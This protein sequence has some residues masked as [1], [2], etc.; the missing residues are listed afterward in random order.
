MRSTRL[1]CHGGRLGAPAAAGLPAAGASL[2]CHLPPTA[3]RP[4]VAP[5]PWALLSTMGHMSVAAALQNS[6]GTLE[7]TCPEPAVECLSPWRSSTPAPVLDWQRKVPEPRTRACIMATRG[8]A[9]EQVH[10]CRLHCCCRGTFHACARL[11]LCHSSR[12]ATV[13]RSPPSTTLRGSRDCSAAMGFLPAAYCVHQQL[14]SPRYRW[15]GHSKQ[16]VAV[17]SQLPTACCQPLGGA[18]PGKH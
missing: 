11:A 17:P 6:R 9:S 16:L 2:S 4:A 14:C 7:F 12:T 5:A 13:K 10:A 3:L 18:L 1:Q 15:P 8:C